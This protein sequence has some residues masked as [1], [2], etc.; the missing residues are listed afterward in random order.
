MPCISAWHRV[1][2]GVP[3]SQ[4][5]AAGTTVTATY[6]AKS[7][8]ADFEAVWKPLPHLSLDLSGDWQ[9]ALYTGYIPRP[10]PAAPI[11]PATICSASRGCNFA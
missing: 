1:F 6:G 11:T 10:P 4:F 7:S 9:R 5:T 8:G 2:T 3:F